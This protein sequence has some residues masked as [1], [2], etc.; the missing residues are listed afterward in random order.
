VEKMQAA[1]Q[2]LLNLLEANVKAEL[3]SRARMLQLVEA[4]E[5]GVLAAERAAVDGAL[6]ELE[7]ELTRA[8]A[9][10]SARTRMLADLGALWGVDP[11]ALTL[12][13]VAQRMGARAAGLVEARRE[14]REQVALLA[15][16]NRRLGALVALQRRIVRDVVGAVLGD[17]VGDV[18][19]SPGTVLSAEA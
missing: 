7:V 4:Q 19:R 13:S 14:L 11:A 2:R 17:S 15:R 1:E 5:Q 18:F 16:R 8:A 9:Q 6:A 10:A 12:S 3:R